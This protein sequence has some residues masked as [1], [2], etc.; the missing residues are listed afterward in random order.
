MNQEIKLIRRMEKFHDDHMYPGYPFLIHGVIDCE[1]K[2]GYID[3]GKAMPLLTKFFP[4]FESMVC[5]HMVDCS[6]T[7]KGSWLN[8]THMD[9]Y[10]KIL[11]AEYDDFYID[12]LEVTKLYFAL[13]SAYRSNRNTK[14]FIYFGYDGDSEYVWVKVFSS[15]KEIK[16]YIKDYYNDFKD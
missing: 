8:E 7:I 16:Q 12:N 4:K 2:V 9:P 6:L 1:D 5:Y 11:E 15:V 13:Y 14:K 3:G 10:Q